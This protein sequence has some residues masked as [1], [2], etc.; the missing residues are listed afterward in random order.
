MLG[1]VF[2]LASAIKHAYYL[3]D[4]K[5]K[6]S[7]NCVIEH[8]A[9]PAGRI[10]FDGADWS[11]FDDIKNSKENEGKQIETKIFGC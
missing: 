6:E 5:G 11:W 3:Y 4:D 2:S 10:F 8:D 7:G 9:E 1:P